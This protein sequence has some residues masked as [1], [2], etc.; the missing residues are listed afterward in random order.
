MGSDLA[1]QNWDASKNHS[2]HHLLREFCSPSLAP[3][4]ECAAKS[5]AIWLMRLHA[6][7]RPNKSPAD[8]GL[9]QFTVF[10]KSQ[11]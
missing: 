6:I 8:A 9:F 11:F 10:I 3:L 7:A 4:A 5:E 2:P 1:D